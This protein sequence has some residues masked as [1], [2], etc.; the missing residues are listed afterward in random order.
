M[1]EYFSIGIYNVLNI[2][3]TNPNAL[4]EMKITK[5]LLLTGLLFLGAISHTSA[6]DYQ[7]QWAFSGGTYVSPPE[8]YS[9]IIDYDREQI[10]DVKVDSDGNYY[11]LATLIGQGSPQLNAAPLTTYNAPDYGN[12]VLLF[13]VSCQGELR[14][15]RVIGGRENDTAYNMV[16][17]SQDNVYVGLTVQGGMDFSVHFSEDEIIGAYP[18]DPLA[19][20]TLFLAKYDS[21]GN[22]VAKK[23]LQGVVS[24]SNNHG[25]ILHLAIHNDILHFVVGLLSG[26]HL[27]GNVTV[28]EEYAYNSATETYKTQFHLAQYDANLNYINSHV[29]DIDDD[30]V[31]LPNQTRFVYDAQLNR[32]YIVGSRSFKG[33]SPLFP[34]GN[35]GRPIEERCFIFAINGLNGDANDGKELWRREL[36]THTIPL[37]TSSNYLS[38]IVIDEDSNIYLGANLY[39]GYGT[40]NY[41]QVFD[42]MDEQ[43]TLQVFTSPVSDR[44]PVLIKMNPATGN[45]QWLKTPTGNYGGVN[46]D[47]YR[48]D[49]G[50]TLNGDEIAFGISTGKFFW[51]SVVPTEGYEENYY[52]AMVRFDRN[53]ATAL[54]LHSIT[55]QDDVQG[56]KI[57]KI[58]ADNDG[59]YIAGGMFYTHVFFYHPTMPMLHATGSS[60]FFIAKLAASGCGTHV[61][62]LEAPANIR[63][64]IYPN[65]T[66]D[67]LYINGDT[68]LKSYS[69]YD[70]NGRKLKEHTLDSNLQIP[71]LGLASGWYLIQ[72]TTQ[73]GKQ[74]SY[75]VIKN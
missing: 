29:L 56:Q 60:D 4:Y 42:S 27:D 70:V 24:P 72:L 64:K 31:F 10:Y 9:P 23:A 45:V 61:A 57:T 18:D 15:S 46:V 49:L 71:M 44:T 66:A 53:T 35:E 55:G 54:G 74:I 8:A 6:Q 7:W 62:S 75:K 17:D 36:R 22:F 51:D 11:F 28:P 58:A 39:I 38:E 69:I 21:D 40:D 67:V 50:L 12:D 3:T 59:N 34:M 26:T 43:G 14:W 33:F 20:N 47:A 30:S 32:Y 2:I 52:P 73:D 41:V 19:L 13:S 63:L 37:S 5:I 25:E 1:T 16:L 65:P 68:E 48:M